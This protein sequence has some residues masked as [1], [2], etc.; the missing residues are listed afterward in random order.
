MCNLSAKFGAA[1]FFDNTN[2]SDIPHV[3]NWNVIETA[4]DKRRKGD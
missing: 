3:D 1:E 4:L 2:M